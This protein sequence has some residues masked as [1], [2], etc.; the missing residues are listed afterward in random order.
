MDEVGSMGESEVGGGE[1]GVAAFAP[2]QIPPRRTWHPC[3]GLLSGAGRRPG[4][5]GPRG[6]GGAGPMLEGRGSCGRGEV[7]GG[8]H[9][10]AGDGLAGFEQVAQVGGGEVGEAGPQATAPGDPGP[11]RC[12]MASSA[13]AVWRSVSHWRCGVARFRA[14]KVNV[15][16]P[17]LS[18]VRGNARRSSGQVLAVTGRP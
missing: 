13:E 4:S 14:R 12:S 7:D 11:A 9:H 15:A 2:I 10:R 18:S 3:W 5:G 8:S 1:G 6:P 16:W 17:V